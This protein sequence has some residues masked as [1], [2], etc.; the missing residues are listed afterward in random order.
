M[1]AKQSPGL[2]AIGLFAVALTATAE[3]N[4]GFDVLHQQ[5][6][7][8]CDCAQIRASGVDAAIQCNDFTRQYATYSV[9]Y[10][11][12]WDDA[13][14]A[15]EK[16]LRNLLEYCLTEAKGYQQSMDELGLLGGGLG[17]GIDAPSATAP[18]WYRVRV[19]E[20][21]ARRGQLVRIRTRD[22]ASVTGVLSTASGSILSVRLAARDGGGERAIQ[23]NDVADVRVL[24]LP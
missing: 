1:A 20:L 18:S 7:S 5:V 22:G 24:N 21:D 4:K 11:E 16:K 15:V 8:A 17:A 9:D 3:S 19:D 2:V 12:H 13:D 23:T 14:R 10:R 6:R